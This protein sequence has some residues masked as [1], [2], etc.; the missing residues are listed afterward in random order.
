MCNASVIEMQF[1]YQKITCNNKALVSLQNEM[2]LFAFSAPACLR[3]DIKI[4][5]RLSSFEIQMVSRRIY[6]A[7]YEFWSQLKTCF[8]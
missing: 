2:N 8:I 1:S 3:A 6:G 5:L 7:H 4:S